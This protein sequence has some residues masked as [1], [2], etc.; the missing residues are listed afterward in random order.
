M[1]NALL[2]ACVAF[3][4]ME[5]LGHFLGRALLKRGIGKKDS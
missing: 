4:L 2:L 3:V 5:P 1:T